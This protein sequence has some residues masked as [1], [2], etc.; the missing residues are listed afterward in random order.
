MYDPENKYAE[1]FGAEITEQLLTL[2]MGEG[3]KRQIAGQSE[4]I[5]CHAAQ[6][7]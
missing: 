3:S 6:I 5:P 2:L 7:I 1:A 4:L